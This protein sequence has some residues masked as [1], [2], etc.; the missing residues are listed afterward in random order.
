MR[1]LEQEKLPFLAL[2]VGDGSLRIPLQD[3]IQKEG[4]E[5]KVRF[6]GDTP[7]NKVRELM[8]AGDIVFLPSENEGI[9]LTIFEGMASGVVPV[10]A[11]V[12]GRPELV[13]PECGILIPRSSED[14]EAETYAQ[15]LAGLIRQPE[16]RRQMALN[17]RERI[18]KQFSLELM[19]ERMESLI[20]KAGQLRKDPPRNPD[21][22]DLIRLFS[23][24]TAE[25]FRVNEFLRWSAPAVINEMPPASASTYLYFA[26]RQLTYPILS[27]SAEK[28]GFCE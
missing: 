26:F 23:R 2:V 8:A 9:S 28:N 22:D 17:S 7:Q 25:Y 6:L 5:E 27:V 16:K 12:G 3:Y 15:A 1:L 4:L 13:T 14:E 10:G 19:G 11:M 20:Y 21:R 18:E 24:Q